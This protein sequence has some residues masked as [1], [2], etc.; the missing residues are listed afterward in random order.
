MATTEDVTLRVIADIR[1]YQKKFSEL[2][3]ITEKQA[4]SLAI[5]E[6]R[7]RVSEEARTA[8]LI[9]QEARRA[10]REAERAD[11]D[12]AKRRS[13]SIREVQAAYERATGALEAQKRAQMS[14][15]QQAVADLNKEIAAL[16]RLE[17]E[18]ADATQVA[19]ARQAV[20]MAGAQ[21][22]AA[23][24][25][26][27]L[28]NATTKAAGATAALTKNSNELRNAAQSVAMQLPDVFSQLASGTPITTV[29]AQQGMQVLQVNMGLVTKAAKLLGA[30]FSGPML[31]AITVVVAALGILYMKLKEQRE[32]QT[33]LEKAVQRTN[34]AMD[35]NLVKMY[36]EAQRT[37]ASTV[38]E[39][40]IALLQEVGALDSLEISQMRAVEAIRQQGRASLLAAAAQYAKLEVDRIT[41]KTALESGDLTF[42][43]VEAAQKRLAVL[44]EEVPAALANVAAIREQI[45]SQAAQ[46]NE[47]YNQIAAIKAQRDA[48]RDAESAR[49]S[50]AKSRSKDS[51]QAGRDAADEARE[52]EALAEALRQEELA[53][54]STFS[55]ALQAARQPFL[56]QDEITK[57]VNLKVALIDAAMA[58]E[59][60]SGEALAV[61]ES[62]ARINQEI[63]ALQAAGPTA[64]AALGTELS[65]IG[66]EALAAADE[67]ATAIEDS[68]GRM[69]LALI[70]VG[71]KETLKSAGRLADMLTGGGLSS[72]FNPAEIIGQIGEAASPQKARKLARN[73]AKQAVSFVENLAAN[74]GPFITALANNIDKVIVA[75]AKAMP[76]I[77]V[78]LIKSVPKLAIALVKAV[79]QAAVALARSIANQVRRGVR[80]AF[81]LDN[82]RRDRRRV[83]DTPGPMRMP[84]GGTVEVA[85]ND[86]VVA[87]RTEQAVR[88]Q[89][90]ASM[91]RSGPTEVVTV[92]DIRDG[93][94]RLGMSRAT[95]RELDRRGV[96]RDTTGRRRVY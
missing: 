18:G 79:G 43:Q 66:P 27:D 92:I 36:A 39:S 13:A 72:M 70:G 88:D 69:R 41:I 42:R 62:I 16:Q 15:S 10:A 71:I 85:P 67:M 35:P 48:E 40:R 49:S 52:R 95:Q 37:M 91:S 28:A 38:E 9:A 59:L 58:A 84:R 86:V 87:G 12:A 50:G 44:R 96:G 17:K 51:K 82:G 1:D 14:A 23:A 74:I 3:G 61:Q 26:S 80:S 31:A 65:T 57:L 75:I 33:E 78:A 11:F 54:Q 5:K 94:F 45:D 30:V 20:Q 7:I 19:K 24:R 55:A 63:Q 34:T 93:A 89:M 21:K 8:K 68:A 90:G 83:G 76:Q 32:A 46:V 56:Q 22:I 29:L 25:A 47:Y 6:R 81:G 60:T 2:P 73:M 77:I 53:R 4:L 64:V